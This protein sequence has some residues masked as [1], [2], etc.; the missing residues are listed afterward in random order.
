M[1]VVNLPADIDTSK[2][3]AT[4]KDGVLNLELPKAAHAKAVRVEPKGA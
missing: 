2:A 4:L 1:R 3:T